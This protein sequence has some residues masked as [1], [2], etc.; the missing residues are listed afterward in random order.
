MIFLSENCR[1]CRESVS[2]ALDAPVSQFEQALVH[3]HLAMC[4]ECAAFAADVRGATALL[5]A[6]QPVELPAPLDVPLPRRVRPQLAARAGMAVA[7][8]AAVVAALSA[9]GLTGGTQF[10][11]SAAAQASAAEIPSMRLA[12]SQQL[13]PQAAGPD[14]V[15]IRVIEID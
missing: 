4:P 15:R 7:A 10:G 6:A 12:R 11:G 3:R 14:S 1:R 2:L 13:R 5:R 8:A 9:N